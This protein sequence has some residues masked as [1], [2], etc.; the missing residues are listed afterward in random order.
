MAYSIEFY[1]TATGKSPVW[2]FFEELRC[3][4]TNDKNARIQFQQMGLYMQLLQEHGFQLSN[5]I[6]KHLQDDIWEL[7][8]GN[9]RVL[10]FYFKNKTFVLL[11]V[12]RKKTQKTPKREIERAI[13]ARKDYLKRKEIS[14]HEHM[15]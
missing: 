15:E 13:A 10:Y 7:R 8:P 1:E 3:K 6:K 11:H 2:D 5:T 12:F 14:T 9:N 4:S